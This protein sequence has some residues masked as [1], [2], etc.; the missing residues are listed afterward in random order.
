MQGI[1]VNPSQAQKGET[2]DNTVKKGIASQC[3]YQYRDPIKTDLENN[4]H[5]KDISMKV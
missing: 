2:C 4:H 5:R 3:A 1:H